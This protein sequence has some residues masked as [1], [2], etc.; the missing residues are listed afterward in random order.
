MN[1][2][3]SDGTVRC[4]ECFDAS[5]YE[6]ET[7]DPCSYCG[8][9][10]ATAKVNTYAVIFSDLTDIEL[11]F[12]AEVQASSPRSAEDECNRAVNDPG[13]IFEGCDFTVWPVPV[14]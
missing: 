2:R 13:N 10:P 4:G 14:A 11:A 9:V 12:A 1:V 5:S 6:S 8:T 3:L 7:S